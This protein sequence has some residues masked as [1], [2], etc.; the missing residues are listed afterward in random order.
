MKNKT[1]WNCWSYRYKK[2]TNECIWW[3]NLMKKQRTPRTRRKKKAKKPVS[4]KT[5]ENECVQTLLLQLLLR[6]KKRESGAA[7]LQ[8]RERKLSQEKK[9]RTRSRLTPW[10]SFWKEET[11]TLRPYNPWRLKPNFQSLQKSALR[12]RSD[13]RWRRRLS[14]KTTKCVAVKIRVFINIF[15]HIHCGNFNCVFKAL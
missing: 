5:N 15:C 9:G 2:R 13:A 1:E 6:K 12:V 10:T 3:K 14:P 4:I 11:P 8:E 7:L